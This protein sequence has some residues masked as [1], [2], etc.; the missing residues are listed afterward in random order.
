MNRKSIFISFIF[1]F[2]LSQI[3]FSQDITFIN[4]TG[5]HIVEISISPADTQNWSPDI[6]PFD[7]LLNDDHLE[8]SIPE[9]YRSEELNFRFTDEDGET[10]LITRFNPDR[11]N[12]VV[13]LIDDHIAL[14]PPAG[15]TWTLIL[16]N[17][18]DDVLDELKISGHDQSEWGFNL[19]NGGYLYPGEE[20]VLE[21]DPFT[22][23]GYFDVR[24]SIVR[25]S[26]PVYQIEKLYLSPSAIIQL[27]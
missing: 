1:L 20:F 4:R 26:G 14:Q 3:L 12:K 16:I 19:L 2:I 23:P 11:E 10:Y 5:F 22:E 21:M 6:I 15:E 25:E 24:Y 13:I 17:N 9:N 18:S 27:P 7:I 8:Y